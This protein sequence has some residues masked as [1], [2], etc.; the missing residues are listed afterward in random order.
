MFVHT[1]D[2]I[3]RNSHIQLELRQETISWEV[4]TSSCIHT[5]STYEDG[6]MIETTLQLEK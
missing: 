3:P 2:T 4:L 1:L 5:F 6:L